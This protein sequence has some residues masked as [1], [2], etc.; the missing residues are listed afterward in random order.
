MSD[1]EEAMLSTIEDEALEAIRILGI[2]D[3]QVEG[4]Q[5]VV[6]DGHV[7]FVGGLLLVERALVGDQSPVPR[8]RLVKMDY[9]D[10]I[11]RPHDK[12]VNIAWT[13]C[14]LLACCRY[15]R[16]VRDARS[17]DYVVIGQAIAKLQMAIKFPEIRDDVLQ[18]F[19]P[20]IEL[21]IGV[22]E[23]RRDFGKRRGQDL[24]DERVKVW[25]RWVVEA[26]KIIRKD[27]HLKIIQVAR[28][29]KKNL[30]LTESVE[31]IRMRIKSAF[32]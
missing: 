23:R 22:R 21:G 29:V 18:E 15:V 12:G 25:A 7:G 11:S 1:Y 5:A 9:A 8:D 3:N 19:R 13:G 17:V 30:N 10:P 26:K 20:D 6:V 28:I 27:L 32:E 31:T 24:H 16:T 2:E 4:L 14:M